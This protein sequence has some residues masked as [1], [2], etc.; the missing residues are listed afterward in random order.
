MRPT[1]TKHQQSRGQLSQAADTASNNYRRNMSGFAALADFEGDHTE[2]VKQ[3][4][5]AKAEK[6]E[7]ATAK[8]NKAKLKFEELKAKAGRGAWGDSDDED[9]M[10]ASPPVCCAPAACPLCLSSLPVLSACTLC[11]P[12]SSAAKRP[13]SAVAASADGAYEAA[14]RPGASRPPAR[15]AAR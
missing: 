3:R 15:L 6:E 4:Q 14:S 9:D 1:Q 7:E 13:T 10:F 11:Q 12:S 5:K 8:A 2:I